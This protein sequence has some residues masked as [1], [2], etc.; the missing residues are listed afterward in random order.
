MRISTLAACRTFWSPVP[1]DLV[2]DQRLLWSGFCGVWLMWVG[3]VL[4]F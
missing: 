1:P 4:V 3:S 2:L